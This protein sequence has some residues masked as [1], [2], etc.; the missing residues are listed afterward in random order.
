M[1]RNERGLT[2][3]EL[4]VTLTILSVVSVVIWN[5]FF[6]GINY[7]KKASSQNIIQ[8]ESNIL[9]MKLTKIHQTSKSYELKS[10]NCKI[11]VDYTSQDGFLNNEEFVHGDLCMST[12]FTGVV[13]PNKDDLPLTITIRDK[14]DTSNEF[15][16]ET[17]FYRLKGDSNE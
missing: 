16:V 17:V 5:V 10:T 8:Q 1:I 6:Q 7:S 9:T 2:L 12:D 4:L 13:D 14:E 11:T 15:V 3:I